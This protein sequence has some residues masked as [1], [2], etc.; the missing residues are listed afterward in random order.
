MPDNVDDNTVTINGQ[1][2]G[3][4]QYFA[5]VIQEVTG[6]DVFRIEPEIPYPTD[7]S[8]LVDQAL[9]EQSAD[10]R[11]AMEGII[12]NFEDYD[13]VFIGYPI[14]WSDLLQI[15]YTFFDTYDFSG[16]AIVP[17]NIHGGSGWAGTLDTI[18]VLEPDAVVLD[19]LSIS[20]SNIQNARNEITE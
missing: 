16:K 19:G 17:F 20:R 15:M 12:E 11:S 7:H 1:T 18:A 3:N 2:L 4:N 6:A 13:T 8:T 9:E 14:W 5:Q 10:A